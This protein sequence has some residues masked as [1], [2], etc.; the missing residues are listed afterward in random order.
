MNRT[1]KRLALPLGAAVVLGTTGFAFMAGGNINQT[2]A[3]TN[4]GTIAA[5]TVS[6]VH[7]TLHNNASSGHGSPGDEYISAVSFNLDQPASTNGMAAFVK[8]GTGAL[9]TTRYGNCVA[10]TTG[11]QQYTCTISHQPSGTS[12]ANEAP[13]TT[14][15]ELSVAA[16]Q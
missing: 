1:I 9:S 15:T 12:D 6:G 11:A 10:N 8:N 14:A 13:L 5:F 7:Y 2:Y 3:G 4:T 16:A